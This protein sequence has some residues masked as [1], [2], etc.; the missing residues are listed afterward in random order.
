MCKY[1]L[2]F[3]KYILPSSKDW[4]G[5][6]LLSYRNVYMCPTSIS[7]ENIQ[8][9]LSIELILKSWTQLQQRLTIKDPPVM[10]VFW[11]F[12]K[13]P[14][15]DCWTCQPLVTAKNIFVSVTHRRI[16]FWICISR[17]GLHYGIT[18]GEWISIRM[19]YGSNHR[20]G[21]RSGNLAFM[22]SLINDDDLV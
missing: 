6:G 7:R 20:S 18:R 4:T 10:R 14:D 11:A 5:V 2:K 19:S 8:V 3:T 17:V 1:L 12:A 21:D 22:G 9:V 15:P 16:L 13:K